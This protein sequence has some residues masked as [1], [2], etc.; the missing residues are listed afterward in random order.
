MQEKN[1]SSLFFIGQ[2]DPYHPPS[3]RLNVL[4]V[5][6]DSDD[7][8]SGSETSRQGEEGV[9]GA[10]ENSEEE[11]DTEE[12]ATTII[13]LGAHDRRN[14]TGLQYSPFDVN[15]PIRAW[16]QIFTHTI[17]EKIVKYTNKYGFVHAKRWKDMTRKDLESFF[18][19][20]FISGIQ[21]RKDK[22][23]NWFL[24]NKLLEPTVIKKE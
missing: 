2:S 13:P 23:S 9:V 22:P 24:E 18:A 6:N 10:D 11:A 15:S 12:V 20:L 3:I 14:K 8:D 17:L 4:I 16:R 5:E 21:K 19:V 1:A 7:S